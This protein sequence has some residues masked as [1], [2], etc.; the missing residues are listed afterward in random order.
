MLDFNKLYFSFVFI[1]MYFFF[2]SAQ[3]GCIL[4]IVQSDWFRERAVFFFFLPLT[5]VT[6]TT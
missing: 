5:M 1:S 2:L 4:R 3:V 6:V